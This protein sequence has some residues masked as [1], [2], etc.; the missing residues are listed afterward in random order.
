[1]LKKS[2][3]FKIK[4]INREQ[5]TPNDEQK[6]MN[7]LTPNDEQKTFFYFKFSNNKA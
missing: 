6:V 5:E 2:F 7:F 4:E 3:S 1:M